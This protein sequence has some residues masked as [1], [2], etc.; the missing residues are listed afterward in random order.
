MRLQFITNSNNNLPIE[1]IHLLGH[2][3]KM[4]IFVNKKI[5]A[6]IHGIIKIITNSPKKLYKRQLVYSS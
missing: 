4:T 1:N 6:K 2:K 3:I 5:K